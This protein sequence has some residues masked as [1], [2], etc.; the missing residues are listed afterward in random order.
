MDLRLKTCARRSGGDGK[1]SR[2]RKF[3]TAFQA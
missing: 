1:S 2:L 3:G